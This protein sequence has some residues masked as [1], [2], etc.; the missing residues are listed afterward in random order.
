MSI[1]NSILSADRQFWWV[2]VEHA[3][4]LICSEDIRERR[5][6]LVVLSWPRLTGDGKTINP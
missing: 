2:V 5:P 4:T 1:K 6:L 3:S